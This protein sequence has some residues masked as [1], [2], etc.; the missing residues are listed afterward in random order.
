M[1]CIMV[2]NSIGWK[3]LIDQALRLFHY[4][5]WNVQRYGN[6]KFSGG[7]HIESLPEPVKLSDVIFWTPFNVLSLWLYGLAY[8]CVVFP[9][10]SP[11][12]HCLS[13]LLPSCCSVVWADV[14]PGCWMKTSSSSPSLSS[15]VMCML[16]QLTSSLFILFCFCCSHRH[17][18]LPSNQWH[19]HCF[20]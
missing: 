11:F 18:P 13:S 15:L 8:K 6:V 5:V 9:S 16:L 2:V 19:N 14:C 17:R 4:L 20:C 10:S 12:Y 3:S 7:E 1:V